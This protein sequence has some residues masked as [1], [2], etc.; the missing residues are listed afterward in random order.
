MI[1]CC[2]ILKIW[3]EVSN[4]DV[5]YININILNSCPTQGRVEGWDVMK[6]L[7]YRSVSSK[8]AGRPRLS[9][10]TRADEMKRNGWDECGE[11]GGMKFVVGENGRNP[12]KNLPRPRFVHHET[13]MERP[14]CEL[15]TPAVG[16]E[17]LTACATRPLYVIYILIKIESK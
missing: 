3:L 1:K 8:G 13:H 14:R 9:T 15:G 11:N 16:G 6:P 17:R 12:E 5:I 2:S 4:S 7:Y 10:I